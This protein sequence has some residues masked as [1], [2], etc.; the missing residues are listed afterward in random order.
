MSQSARRICLIGEVMIELSSVDCAKTLLR[1]ACS[2]P[3]TPQFISRA[4]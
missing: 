3:T 1:L 2:I 4:C